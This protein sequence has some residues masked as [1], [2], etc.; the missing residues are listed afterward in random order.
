MMTTL[1]FTV[2]Q[3]QWLLDVVLAE[4]TPD[5]LTNRVLTACTRPKQGI[6]LV[7]LPPGDA[8]ALSSLV[9][10]RSGADPRLDELSRRLSEQLAGTDCPS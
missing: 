9:Q 2:E 10:A 5:Y 1:R 7:P 4:E 3:F 6:I 8:V